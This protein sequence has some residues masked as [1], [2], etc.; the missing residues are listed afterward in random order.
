MNASALNVL[1]NT[2]DQN[3]LTVANR[4]NLH[5]GALQIMVNQNRMLCRSLYS[6]G[7][8]V[9]QLIIVIHDF[10]STA[11]QHVGRTN[12]GGIA[13][14]MSSVQCALRVEYSVSFRTRNV[15]ISKELLETLAVFG[16]VNAIHGRAQH[17]HA[18]AGQRT[19]QVNSGLTTK[20]HDN[21]L[22]LLFIDNI[23]HILHSQGLKVQLVSNIE[24]SGN[25]FRV[26]INDNGFVTK[27]LQGPYAMY[28]AI[29]KLYALTDTDRT[30]AQYNNLLFVTNLN[31]VLSFVAGI[32]VRSSSLK[33]SSAGIYHLIGGDDTVGL[34]HIAN[35]KLSLAYAS[36]NGLVGK[37]HLLSLAQQAGS[38]LMGFQ[39]TLHLDDVLN[40]RQ[41]PFINLSNGVDFVNG[42]ATTHSLSDYKATF[43][44][45]ILDFSTNFFIT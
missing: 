10:H 21:A 44:I 22:G 27:L 36:S 4:V 35:F 30:R 18:S 43:I 31:L 33:L 25:G 29:V 34:T 45:N 9:A 23:Q 20:L 24:V 3:F 11:A 12:H 1:H 13:N 17:L 2:G 40:L 42:Y 15:A 32:V 8:V 38:E 14:I 16:A 37:A 6:V 39:S 41:E 5:L 7:H 26:V 19:C 28:G